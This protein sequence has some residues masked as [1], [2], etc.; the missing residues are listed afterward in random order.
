MY[1]I[2]NP[3]MF[4]EGSRLLPNELELIEELVKNIVSRIKTIGKYNVT[5]SDKNYYYIC[6]RSLTN[7]EWYRFDDLSELEKLHIEKNLEPIF[8]DEL[9]LL[10]KKYLL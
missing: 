1:D 3:Y 7:D 6:F 5:C 8:K 2:L 4:N 10:C 9:K